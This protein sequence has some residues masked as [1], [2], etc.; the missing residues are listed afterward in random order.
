MSGLRRRPAAWKL[1]FEFHPVKKPFAGASPGES[2]AERGWVRPG[3]AGPGFALSLGDL[4]LQPSSYLRMDTSSETSVRSG[5][6][7]GMRWDEKV[8]IAGLAKR[9]LPV[10]QS[11]R[12]NRTTSPAPER[13]ERSFGAGD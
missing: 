2:E 1:F 6:F 7:G 11:Q 13:V 4:A 8:K 12:N 5:G 9:P 3:A 10:L